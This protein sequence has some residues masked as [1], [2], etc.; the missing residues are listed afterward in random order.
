MRTLLIALLSLAPLWLAAAPDTIPQRHDERVRQAEDFT[1]M[2][3]IDRAR[4]LLEELLR[5]MNADPALGDATDRAVVRMHLLTMITRSEPDRARRITAEVDS[6]LAALD[7]PPARLLAQRETTRAYVLRQLGNYAQAADHLALARPYLPEVIRTHVPTAVTILTD[8]SYDGILTNGPAPER[9]DVTRR[10]LELSQRHDYRP[11]VDQARML[12]AITY[13]TTGRMEAAEAT[14]L[15]AVAYSEAHPELYAR[16]PAQ[17]HNLANFYGMLGRNEEA[18]AAVRGAIRAEHRHFPASLPY[19]YQLEGFLLHELGKYDSAIAALDSAVV[20][21]SKG[22]PRR[23]GNHRFVD[24]TE[25]TNLNELFKVYAKRGDSRQAQGDTLAALRDYR[26]AFLV[27]ET[28]RARNPELPGRRYWAAQLTSYSDQAVDL[29]L[30]DPRPAKLWEALALSDRLK[31]ASLLAEA[32]RRRSIGAVGRSLINRIA[33]LERLADPTPTQRE[34][35]A[36]LRIERQ[37]I[38]AD[39]NLQQ[40]PPVASARELSAYVAELGRPVISYYIGDARGFYLYAR[41]DGRITADSFPGRDS[42]AATITR[43][44][45]SITTG[46]YRRRSLRSPARQAAYDADFL[47]LGAQLAAWLLPPGEPPNEL[48]LL[49]DGPLHYLP[50]AALPLRHTPLPPGQP[51]DYATLPLL[52]RSADLQLAPSLD[53][54]RRLNDGTD[55]RS[56][57]SS[58]L[59]ALAPEFR[60]NSTVAELR[61]G[62]RNQLA[63]LRHSKVEVRTIAGLVPAADTLIGANATLQNFLERAPRARILHLS[64]H[65]LASTED[66]NQSFIAFAQHSDTTREH[67]LLFYNDLPSLALNADLAV[68]SACETNLGS[69]AVGTGN[70]SVS[71]AFAA[72]GAR[73]TLSTLWPVDDAATS[74]LIVAFYTALLQGKSRSQALYL[75]RESLANSADYAHPY[76]WAGYVLSGA[77]TPLSLTRWPGRGGKRHW[78]WLLLLVLPGVWWMFRRGGGS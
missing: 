70:L 50:F 58:N 54:L 66:P 64:T 22:S 74:R 37:A 60:G 48:L 61:V 63:P 34:E 71:A 65:G 27:R 23:E 7:P 44:N 6:I 55:G 40:V 75:A 10:A 67:D 16:V 51:A 28:L 20:T 41:P 36:R 26:E 1:F 69:F 38:Y 3:M 4:P 13:A 18:L 30:A 73:S 32:E 68:L 14:F 42:L 43:W 2:R 72:A 12:L 33:P 53:Y 24:L 25:V 47:A 52:G 77:N 29:L 46:S 57:V 21:Y 31:G 35:L 45:R 78:P 76:Y 17:Y 39:S 59:L 11:G 5:D 19:S 8:L 15:K 62:Q 9:L 56:P 49:P